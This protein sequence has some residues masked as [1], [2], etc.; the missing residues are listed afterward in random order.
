MCATDG[1]ATTVDTP[2]SS[3][4]HNKIER[5]QEV[6]P[7]AGAGYVTRVV[8]KN[9]ISKQNMEELTGSVSLPQFVCNFGAEL[10]AIKCALK[11]IAELANPNENANIHVG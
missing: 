10:V 9:K 4:R 7:G 5:T 11:A 2:R 6:E 8:G 3:T 1:A